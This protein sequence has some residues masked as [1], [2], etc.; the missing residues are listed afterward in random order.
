[1]AQVRA[2]EEHWSTE[3]VK[4][5]Y[6]YAGLLDCTPSLLNNSGEMSKEGNQADKGRH[7]GASPWGGGIRGYAESLERWRQSGFLDGLKV[8]S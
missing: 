3:T 4:R 6:W 7:M 2:A 1:M 8:R 5:A